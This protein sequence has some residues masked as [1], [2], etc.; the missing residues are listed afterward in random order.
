MTVHVS[1]AP[2]PPGLLLLPPQRVLPASGPRW[3]LE[4]PEG[5]HQDWRKHLALLNL[6]WPSRQPFEEYRAGVI[7]L[8]FTDDETEAWGL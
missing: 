2:P 3:M 8:H 4:L 1:G 6:V 7:Y 5:Q